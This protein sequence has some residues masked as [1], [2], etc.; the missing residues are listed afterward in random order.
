M[1]VSSY[2]Y[3]TDAEYSNA[4]KEFSLPLPAPR[5]RSQ[6]RFAPC[7]RAT[8]SAS[9]LSNCRMSRN[10]KMNGIPAKD[11]L[12]NVA[13]GKATPISAGGNRDKEFV[14]E[15]QGQ[16]VVRQKQRVRLPHRGCSFAQRTAQ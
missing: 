12:P 11:S 3:A 7:T 2:A 13:S 8:A 14:W 16:Q 6:V 5:I 1:F 9:V 15:R 4:R 10:R